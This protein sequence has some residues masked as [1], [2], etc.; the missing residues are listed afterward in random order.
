MKTLY[1]DCQM[2]AAGDMLMGALLELVSDRKKFLEKLNQ[3]GIPG[4]RIEAQKS[5]KCG[6]TG[7]HMEVLVNGDEEES[8]DLSGEEGNG[9]SGHNYEHAHGH[10]PIRQGHHV[11]G[12]DHEHAHHMRQGEAIDEE[13]PD[14]EHHYHEHSHGHHS[15]FSMEDI[16]GIIDGL[17][18]DNKVKEDVKNIYQI[19]AQAESQVHGLPV[20][21]VHFHEV[22]AMDAVA[23][24]T[25]CAMLF[26]ELGAE[27]IIVSPVTTGYG[28]VRC[29]H[30]ILPVP[31]PAT[32]L[33]LQGIPCQAGRIEGELCTP[34]GG[35]LLK[36]FA[37]EYGRM[38]Q[39]IMEKIGY[40]MGKKDFEAANCIRAILGEA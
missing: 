4:V 5:V 6:I 27:K 20:A 10:G 22:G 19:I 17:H 37:T 7:T 9:H 15:H 24:I 38:P 28:Q 31:A 11:H 33:I 34:T 25:G 8:L 3:A 1:I 36:Y 12:H 18:A 35:A 29:A 16:T 32:A 14:H 26:R 30:G 23:D 39:M 13:K 2:G 21:E 40:G